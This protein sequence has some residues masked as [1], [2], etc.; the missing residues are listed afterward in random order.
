MYVSVWD[1]GKDDKT[2]I[3]HQK[4][5]DLETLKIKDDP[6]D[7]KLYDKDM[8]EQFEESMKFKDWRYEIKSTYDVC[9]KELKEYQT[10]VV[11]ERDIFKRELEKVQNENDVLLGK[12]IAKAQ[13][14]RNEDINL[15][16]TTEELRFYCLQK[17]EEF[18][19]IKAAER[20]LQHFAKI[21]KELKLQNFISS[22]GVT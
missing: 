20:E 19:T 7:K 8:L 6:M 15:L 9:H 3:E 5:W 12:H 17:Q 4:F 10:T 2:L 14:M 13:Q 18:V 16:D 22:Q 21:V 11:V 1:E